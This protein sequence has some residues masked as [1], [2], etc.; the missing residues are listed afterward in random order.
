[1]HG[2]QAMKEADER[3]QEASSAA[4]AAH[5]KACAKLQ[6]EAAKQE[7]ALRE[8]NSR[9]AQKENEHAITRADLE[10]LHGSTAQQQ[11]A[12]KV[13]RAKL[14]CERDGALSQVFSFGILQRLHCE[15]L[16]IGACM[17]LSA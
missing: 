11:K 12:W 9:L 7:E 16:R 17:A 8:S 3:N 13:E 5:K 6:A 4:D 14:A 1:L 10:A 15:S 2:V